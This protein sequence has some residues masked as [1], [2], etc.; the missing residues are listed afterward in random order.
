MRKPLTHSLRADPNLVSEF[1]CRPVFGLQQ[2]PN[3]VPYY[4][5]IMPW[6]GRMARF[7]RLGFRG[8]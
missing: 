8:K 6:Q 1:P 2:E 3:I 4:D 5:D 7:D